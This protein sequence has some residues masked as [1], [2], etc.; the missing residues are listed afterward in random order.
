MDYLNE[1]LGETLDFVNQSISS[2][3]DLTPKFC[4]QCGSKE[5][6]ADASQDEGQEAWDLT[7]KTCGYSAG[8]WPAEK[9]TCDNCESPNGYANSSGEWQCDNCGFSETN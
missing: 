1:Y 9:P 2:V 4:P 6:S 8:L 3:N 5:L 7:C